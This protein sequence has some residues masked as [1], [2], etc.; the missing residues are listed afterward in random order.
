M[1]QD[2]KH[3]ETILHAALRS[4]APA[5]LRAEGAVRMLGHL[6]VRSL[7][8]GALIQLEGLKLRDVLPPAGTPVT[9]TLLHGEDVVSIRTRLLEPILA[10]HEPKAPPVVQ[11]AWPTEPLQVHP[12][13]AVRVATADLP[14][15]EATLIWHGQRHSAKLLNL[16][17]MGLGLGLAEELEIGYH[18]QV[19]VT[20]RL[21]GAETLT[22]QGDVRH[23][24]SLEGD[25][26]PTRLG[27]V[28]VDLPLETREALQRFIQARRMDRSTE[29][30][31]H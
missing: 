9:L 25:E 23:V 15:L 22:V 16:T 18:D 19:E 27:L 31:G 6:H 1:T 20:T 29:I 4:G 10:E 14:P 2:D 26:L 17:D 7:E 13:R 12:R 24:E 3:L 21:P 28:L 30:R 11:A 5:S 8:P